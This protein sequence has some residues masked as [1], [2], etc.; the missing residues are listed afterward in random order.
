M[1]DKSKYT[2]IHRKRMSAPCK[3]LHTRNL[4]VGKVLDYGCGHGYDADTLG[5]TAYDHEWR[6]NSKVLTFKY[7]TIQCI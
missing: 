7:D 2:A 4:H 6:P 1:M 5:F 3:W